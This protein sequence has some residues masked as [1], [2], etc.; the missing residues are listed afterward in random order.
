VAA[1]E[2]AHLIVADLVA[3]LVAQAAVQLHGGMALLG[4][5]LLVRGE[6]GVDEGVVCA[7]DRGRGRLGPGVGAGLGL[8]ED[9]PDLAP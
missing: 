6:D 7:E 5:R 8:G 3:V 1:D 4:R 2:A 9:L